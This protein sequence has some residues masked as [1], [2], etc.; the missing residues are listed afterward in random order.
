MSHSLKKMQLNHSEHA[1]A[2][3][4]DATTTAE[5][6]YKACVEWLPE[7]SIVDVDLKGK[8]EIPVDAERLEESI[9]MFARNAKELALMEICS[10]SIKCKMSDYGI[11]PDHKR[12][13]RYMSMSDGSS[14]FSLNITAIHPDK[15][16][17]DTTAASQET[18]EKNTK[19]MHIDKL[20]DNMRSAIWLHV[21]A[22]RRSATWCYQLNS[23]CKAKEETN[24]ESKA[25]E[26]TNSECKAKEEPDSQSNAKEEQNSQSKAN[27]QA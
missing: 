13:P 20:E 19:I 27:E 18:P 14:K 11:V 16:V 5:L 22:N 1:G 17:V 8:Y 12:F 3:K 15:E 25:K 9:R 24:S 23:E 21:V 2:A 26:E 10:D 6:T 4:I 7:L